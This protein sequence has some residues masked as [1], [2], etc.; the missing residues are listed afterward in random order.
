MNTSLEGQIYIYFINCLSLF[1]LNEA[2]YEVDWLTSNKHSESNLCSFLI[3]D[4]SI[5]CFFYHERSCLAFFGVTKA[6]IT[7][8][9]STYIIYR[10]LQRDVVY[11][12]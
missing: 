6:R 5:T 1:Y 10:G 3:H 8:F 11:L 9:A 2:I 12:C 7:Y 4:L